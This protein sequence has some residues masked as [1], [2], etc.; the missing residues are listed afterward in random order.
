[1]RPPGSERIPRFQLAPRTLLTFR[2]PHHYLGLLRHFLLID[3]GDAHPEPGEDLEHPAERGQVQLHVVDLNDRALLCVVI[4]VAP[5]HLGRAARRRWSK[6]DE[7]LAGAKD[8]P[9]AGIAYDAR[10]L[11]ERPLTG[12]MPYG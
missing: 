3:K 2:F 9:Q 5:Q 12:A 1:M 8:G 11:R 10:S 7:W 4:Y 6:L